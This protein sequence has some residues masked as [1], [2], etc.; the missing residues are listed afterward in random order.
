[1]LLKTLLPAFAVL[2][3]SCGE[4]LPPFSNEFTA[5]IQLNQLGYY[6]NSPKKAIVAGE[7]AETPF[8]VVNMADQGISFEGMASNKLSWELAGGSYAVMDFSELS[9]PGKYTIYLS[10]VG[11]SYPFVIGEEVYKEAFKGA[12]KSLFYQRA[13]IGLEEQYAGIWKREAGH[14]DDQVT[15]HPSSGRTGVA[16]SPKGW[17]DAGDYGKYVVNGAFP[18]GQMLTLYEQ[19]PDYLEDNM[20]NIPESGNGI[21]DFLDEMKYELDWLLSMQD[22]DGGVFFKLTTKRFGGM[23][24]PKLSEAERFIIGKGTASSLDLAAV[25]AKASRIFKSIDQEYADRCLETAQ[26]AWKWAV[27][28]PAV[29]YKNP[30][31]VVTGEYGDSDFS[32]E[33]YWAAA[34]L[35]VTTGSTEYLEYLRGNQV[36]FTFEPGESWR[37]HMHYL[38]AFTLIDN[39]MDKDLGVDL[40]SEILNAADNLVTLSNEIDY[41]QPI[42]DFQWGSNS[43]VMNSA[44]IIAQAYRLDPQNRYLDTVLEIT[45]YIF[46]KNPN[47][48]SYLTGYGS[49]TPQ[50]IHHRQSAGDGIAE[51][52]PGL[53]AGGP[54]S[55]RQDASEVNYPEEAAPMRCWVD[56][57]ASYASNEI[58]LNWNSALIYVLGFN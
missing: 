47:G 4:T 35:F 17:Y 5:A 37:N 20:L 42:S 45:D 3:T 57:E 24:M 22:E 2:L 16:S 46:G 1:M 12:T 9:Q 51:P 11:Y 38:G 31:D 55:D 43:D 14:L 6:P 53:L 23:V 56:E 18:L 48:Y 30:E 44:M 32:Q 50:F 52:V 7:F 10:E 41:F 26:K 21:S 13:G 36:D 28:N 25:S 54:N 39:D 33:F 15:F 34:E 19:Y 27:N 29:V 58:C 49:K 8:K 40:R